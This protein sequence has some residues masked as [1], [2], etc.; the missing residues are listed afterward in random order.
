MAIIRPIIALIT[1]VLGGL[2]TNVVDKEEEQHLNNEKPIQVS[3]AGLKK[4]RFSRMMHYAFV[5]FLQDISKWLIIGLLLAAVMA[6]LIPDD[7]FTNY[8]ENEY[9]SMLLVLVASIPLY[10]CA[11][12]SVPI[13]AVLLMKGIS[14]GAAI[15][16]LMAGP[17]T[18]AA[19]ITVIGK[20]LG[21]KTLISYLISII[22]GALLFGILVNEVLPREWFTTFVHQVHGG[23]G[24]H[25]LPDWLKV[26]SSILLIGLLINGYV[27][28]YAGSKK[29]TESIQ[30]DMLEKTV[31]VNGMTCNHCKANVQN[32]LASIAGIENIDI[33]LESGKV[34][35]TGD[36]IDLSEVKNKV[37]SIGYQY[38]GEV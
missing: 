22:G 12:G 18:N 27:Q 17:A 28:K 20:V 38:M 32:N 10:V 36:E 29:V 23:H 37:E 35:M 33:D 11:T 26:T 34:T 30:T 16:F 25:L 1:G 15:V 3:E 5:E 9:L 7:F 4:S 24:S 21:R 6:V 31:K 8:L 14:P 13:A 2:F 19:T